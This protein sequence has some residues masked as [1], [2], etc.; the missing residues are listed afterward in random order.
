MVLKQGLIVTGIGVAVG[1]PAAIGGS[2]LVSSLLYEVSPFDLPTLAA[3]TTILALTGVLAGCWP[4]R[5]A[6]RLNPS[7]TLRCD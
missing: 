2:R 1:L 3:S 7:Q 4:A 6:A 5:R